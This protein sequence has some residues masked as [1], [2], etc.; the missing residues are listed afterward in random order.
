MGDCASQKL[1]AYDSFAI[2]DSGGLAG[3]RVLQENRAVGIT[4]SEGRVLMP[5][6]RAFDINRLAID[7]IDIPQDATVDDITRAV[8]PQYHSGVIVKGQVK[9]SH[10]ALL[11]LVDA[12]G[13][14]VPL[15]STATLRTTGIMV[16]V[17][18]DGEAYVQ[19]LDF[20]NEVLVH[21]LDGH[22][23]TVLFEYRPI[24]VEIPAIGPLFCRQ[25]KP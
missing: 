8:R 18:Y 4:N 10:G 25:P 16:P 17:G 14:P 11:R 22:R 2:V 20:H 13:V 23:C 24:V 6:L 5:D 7:P 3:V 12:F 1:R 21:G 9:L 19:D 15:G